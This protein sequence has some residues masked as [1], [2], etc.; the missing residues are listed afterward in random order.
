MD[1]TIFDNLKVVLE[2]SLY[3]LDRE[4]RLRVADRADLVDMASLQRI[5]R[6]G[7]VLPKEPRRV[8][9]EVEIS[10]EL[11]DFAAEWKHLHVI[12][13]KP[14]VRVWLR[15]ILEQWPADE[16]TIR[17][18]HE[19]MKQRWEATDLYHTLEKTMIPGAGQEENRYICTLVFRDKIDEENAG[20]IPLLWEHVRKTMVWLD[21]LRPS[22]ADGDA[23][24][25][26]E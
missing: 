19:E 4:G 21:T 11:L 1:P 12:E 9:G 8:Y 20:E 17:R 22:P 26:K 15:F 14:G 23:S 18:V 3:D 5:F 10:S 7:F 25:A 13:E 24:N 6:L 16:E 2:G